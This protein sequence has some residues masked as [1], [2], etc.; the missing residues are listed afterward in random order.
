MCSLHFKP[1]KNFN[2]GL[3]SCTLNKPENRVKWRGS[4]VSMKCLNH[5][6]DRPSITQGCTWIVVSLCLCL[7][8]IG[9]VAES[10]HAGLCLI[11][12]TFVIAV[13]KDIVM[14]P[15]RSTP[16]DSEKELDELYD[17]FLLVKDKWKTDVSST[18]CF[19]FIIIHFT[20]LQLLNAHIMM[21]ALFGYDIDFIPTYYCKKKIS[22]FDF[23]ILSEC[24]HPG[25]F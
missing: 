23:L 18:V 21:S 13:L 6:I 8:I 16:W 2:F 17:V 14:I 12:R 24:N 10:E 20:V 5:L 22:I 7:S 1:A 11:D 3:F 9:A 15:V 4:Q 25:W 19:F